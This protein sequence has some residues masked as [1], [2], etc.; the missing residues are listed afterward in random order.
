[1]DTLYEYKYHRGRGRP[2]GIHS[3][4]L[5]V[6]GRPIG[7]I[8]STYVNTGNHVI[9]VKKSFDTV[10]AHCSSYQNTDEEPFAILKHDH[11]K[12]ASMSKMWR[13]RYIM[14][15]LRLN[16]EI[17][18]SRRAHFITFA[19]K[20][21]M[22]PYKGMKFSYDGNPI[23]EHPAKYVKQ[24]DDVIS[25]NRMERNAQ[26]RSYYHNN[27][28]EWRLQDNKSYYKDDND[29][30]QVKY[31]WDKI[32]M[33]DVFKLWNVSLRRVLIDHYGMDNII[34]SLSSKVV[35]TDNIKGNEYK[36]VTIRIPDASSE[37]GHRTGTYL[38]MI[39]P[40]TGE[41]HFEGVPN[42][43]PLRENVSVPRWRD[44]LTEQT[45]K[46]ALAWRNRD[47]TYVVPT[48]IT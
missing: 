23:G 22:I 13:L 15:W 31:D 48:A 33:T 39:N 20:S 41:I 9:Y 11:W 21:K 5:K 28:A 16:V 30:T 6:I 35:D 40:S 3:A 29:A 19:D 45:V 12:L 42:Y 34:E 38:R 25:L 7:S 36:L 46:C 47:D 4:Y 32:P 1:M 24:Y 17:N 37:S 27:K 14:W 44:T 26:S 43:I 8:V 10:H 18:W 2:L